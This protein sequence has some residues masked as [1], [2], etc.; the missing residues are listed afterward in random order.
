VFSKYRPAGLGQAWSGY[1]P[2]R[3]KQQRRDGSIIFAARCGWGPFADGEALR[4]FG[5]V[6]YAGDTVVALSALLGTTRDAVCRP[7]Q[8]NGQSLTRLVSSTGFRVYHSIEQFL[9]AFMIGD[10][11]G[12]LRTLISSGLP[13]VFGAGQNEFLRRPISVVI[14]A[15]NEGKVIA[16]TCALFWLQLQGRIEVVVVDAFA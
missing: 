16:E 2:Q 9:W 14:A 1:H 7:L 5:L 12:V 10:R 3:V 4:Y 8:N 15:Y 13:I 6:T 11:S